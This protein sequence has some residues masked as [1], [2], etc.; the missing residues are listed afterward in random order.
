M[1]QAI[2]SNRIFMIYYKNNSHSNIIEMGIFFAAA[3]IVLYIVII[4]I[5]I[6]CFA[7]SSG[8]DAERDEMCSIDSD[9]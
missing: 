8:A 3:I 2:E 4:S 5:A 6:E 7:K 9:W 1:E